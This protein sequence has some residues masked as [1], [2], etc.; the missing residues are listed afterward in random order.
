MKKFF[1]R[2][3][4]FSIIMLSAWFIWNFPEMQKKIS[5]HKYWKREVTKLE[6]AV[7][8]EKWQISSLELEKEK[9]LLEKNLF[10]KQ[11]Y[12]PKKPF[13]TEEELEKKYNQKIQKLNKSVQFT[14]HQMEKTEKKLQSAKEKLS[15]LSPKKKSD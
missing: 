11:K 12:L 7:A 3:F 14:F 8:L 6:N 5:P 2:S 10:Q 4:E 15:S 9:L 1:S 13:L